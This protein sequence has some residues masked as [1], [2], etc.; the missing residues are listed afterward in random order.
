MLAGQMH[1]AASA[2]TCTAH[3]APD[4]PV[5]QQMRI[6]FTPL[7][8]TAGRSL[9]AGPQFMNTWGQHSGWQSVV[10][11]DD[12]GLQRLGLNHRRASSST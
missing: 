10:D 9:G 7:S 3:R 5:V 4:T 8:T 2:A 12:G 6:I 11:D 1:H